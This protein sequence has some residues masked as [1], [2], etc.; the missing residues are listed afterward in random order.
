MSAD[1][2]MWSCSCWLDQD[3]WDV[4]VSVHFL[5]WCP[6]SALRSLTN[7]DHVMV[8]VSSGICSGQHQ[9]FSRAV[10]SEGRKDVF[11]VGQD[12]LLNE[13]R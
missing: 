7:D 10:G 4:P 12:V 3:N 6:R 9:R 1:Y 13:Q 5:L 11:T 2:A 8:F